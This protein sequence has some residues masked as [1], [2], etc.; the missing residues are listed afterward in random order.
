MVCVLCRSTRF[1]SLFTLLCAFALAMAPATGFASEPAAIANPFTIVVSSS[2]DFSGWTADGQGLLGLIPTSGGYSTINAWNGPGAP[3]IASNAVGTSGGDVSGF[4]LSPAVTIGSAAPAATTSLSAAISATKVGYV[5]FG[6]PAANVL[7]ANK[8]YRLRSRLASANAST[9]EEF[10]VRFGSDTLTGQS[11]SGYLGS[12]AASGLPQ[13]PTAATD[14]YSYLITKG[15]GSSNP[16][17]IFYEV[18]S[19]GNAQTGLAGE[20]GQEY[21]VTQYQLDSANYSDLSGASVLFNK[22]GTVTRASG[23]TIAP[24]TAAPTAFALTAD[25]ISQIPSAGEQNNAIQTF[26]LNADQPRARV[27]GSAGSNFTL[28]INPATGAAP[29]GGEVGK[30]WFSRMQ[31]SPTNQASPTGVGNF[32]VSNGKL[33]VLSV[34]M[35]SPTAAGAEVFPQTRISLQFANTQNELGIYELNPNFPTGLT[36]TAR[37][38]HCV[39]EAQFQGFNPGASQV[40]GNVFIDFLSNPAEAYTATKDIVISRVSVTEFDATH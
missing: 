3:P 11:S 33:Y 8:L 5:G 6:R 39:A 16:F 38:Y 18:I 15:T 40:Y 24:P 20:R 12:G 4:T 13:P 35:S 32:P 7:A 21:T 23:E 29:S 30:M 31:F 2:N 26:D 36:T 34:F 9:R 14:Y 19:L 27:L 37:A 22:G 17:Q 1:A 25:Q 10:R 28:R